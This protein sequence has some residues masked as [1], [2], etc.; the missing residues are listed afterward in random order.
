M[1]ILKRIDELR[2]EKGWT[3]FELTNRTN[4]SEYTIY[5]W[6]T[7]G[8]KPTIYALESV[9][10]ALGVTMG[11]FFTEIKKDNL[12]PD[13]IRLLQSYDHLTKEQQELVLSV[14]KSYEKANGVTP[15]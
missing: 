15:D 13:Q 5:S 4:L 7:R 1:D 6:Y 10:E 9:C 3:V 8:S 12:S 11:E 2:R 14:V